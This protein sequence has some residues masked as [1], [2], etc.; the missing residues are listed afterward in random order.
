M[1]S[2]IPLVTT[3]GR[4]GCGHTLF[5]T[6]ESAWTF[7]ASSH[8]RTSQTNIP[9]QS[10][11]VDTYASSHMNATDF[12]NVFTFLCPTYRRTAGSSCSI[13]RCVWSSSKRSHPRPPR[14]LNTLSRGTDTLRRPAASVSSPSLAAFSSSSSESVS[15]SSSS[16]SE[17]EPRPDVSGDA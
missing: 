9:P 10:L 1:T 13:G 12:K 11:P 16:E 6:C 8:V 14:G 3:I 5:T 4:L 2:S 17:P 7:N 15:S